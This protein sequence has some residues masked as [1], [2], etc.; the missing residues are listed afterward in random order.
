MRS[1]LLQLSILIAV[2]V[3][4]I[5]IFSLGFTQRDHYGLLDLIKGRA[6]TGDIA[7]PHS[8]PLIPD[9]K[10]PPSPTLPIPQP[11][12]PPKTTTAR[13][14][15]NLLA[16]VNHLLAQLASSV[17]P[18][19]VS[20]DTS[21][22]VDQ[23]RLV[24]NGPLGI[25]GYVQRHKRYRKP[26]LGS[27]FITSKEGYVI[28]NH[29][30]VAGVDEI[31]ITTHQGQ[32]YQAE[33]IGSDAIVD[34]AILKIIDPENKTFPALKFGD[35]NQTRVG[36]MVLA[37]GNPFG[38]SET[39]TKGIISAKQRQ[40][41]D[42]TNQ[43]LQTDTVI[44]PGNSGGPL[45]NVHGEVIGVNVALFTGQQNVKVWQ[46]VG[47][48]IPANDV[49]EVF[50]A[51]VHKKP[52]I[53]GYLGVDLAQV[54]PYI[55][56]QVGMTRSQGGLVTRVEP[57]SPAATAGLRPG[58]VL[59]SING[60]VSASASD[61]INTIRSKDAQTQLTL[62]ILRDAKIVKLTATISA[63]P[64][65]TSIT[66]RG[67]TSATGQ[68]LTAELGI[69]VR[70]LLP[71][72]RAAY[73]LAQQTSAVLITQVDPAKPAAKRLRKNDLILSI[74]RNTVRNVDELYQLLGSLPDKQQSVMTLAREGTL[75]YAVLNPGK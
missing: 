38:L 16:Q 33:W 56:R 1:T 22:T 35:S 61:L 58:D 8:S 50:E 31:S 63:K 66:M 37:V 65:N 2:L 48:A 69:K 51:I 54:T 10:T 6:L 15:N 20:I 4:S 11:S 9:T 28:T 21:T 13:T 52:L 43:Y 25:F 42:A 57:N 14:N 64:D 68:S 39:V 46:G 23:R 36:E 18:S 5:V 7:N 49:Q 73:G 55:A 44:N 29:H 62:E 32:T 60:K 71:K 47:L 27:G 70:N 26:G 59:L 12:A 30:V 24:P 72:E 3:T 19:V 75:F 53:R 74:N 40:L 67:D 41:S 17:V 34:I 45:I